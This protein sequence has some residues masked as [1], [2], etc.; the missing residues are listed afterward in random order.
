MPLYFG[1][2]Y[3]LSMDL[4]SEKFNDL[5]EVSKVRRFIFSDLGNMGLKSLYNTYWLEMENLFIDASERVGKN[6]FELFLVDYLTIQKNAVIPKKENLLKEFVDFYQ[7]IS[8]FQSR[9]IIIKNIF[10]YSMYYLRITF[11]DLHDEDI[12]RK[13]KT[14]NAL[15]ASDS[16][17]FLMEIFEDYEFAHINR[18]MLLE[19]L[20]TVL[21]FINERN[22][23]KPSQ[24]ALSFAGLST[25]INKMLVLKDYTPHF[26]VEET[27]YLEKETIN[28]MIS[29]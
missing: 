22:S 17:P 5:T 8:K 13:I 3:N 1:M 11:A 12:R 28:S 20:D 27:N 9:E 29:S 25:E 7:E 6:L 4:L 18:A 19:I 26:V 15:N 16:Y 14:I 10:R 24:I 23:K 21:G 2:S